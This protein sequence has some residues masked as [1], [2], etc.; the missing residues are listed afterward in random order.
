[1]HFALLCD[2]ALHCASF[3]GTS[4]DVVVVENPLKSHWTR[5]I[6]RADDRSSVIGPVFN[7]GFSSVA[8]CLPSIRSS[9][10]MSLSAPLLF[11]ASNALVLVR[12]R[13]QHEVEQCEV[14]VEQLRKRVIVVKQS[15]SFPELRTLLH[16]V[17]IGC[18]GN[19]T[20]FFTS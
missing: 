18:S 15:Q 20:L 3:C 17:L 6:W 9:S 19:R 2:F 14:A 12:D 1:V 11:D 7:S 13:F 4:P 8:Y 16:A 10:S 5:G